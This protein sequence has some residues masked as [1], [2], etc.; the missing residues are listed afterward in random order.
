MKKILRGDEES[1]KSLEDKKNSMFERLVQ[2]LQNPNAVVKDKDFRTVVHTENLVHKQSV[3]K[4]KE[5]YAKRE[6]W[7]GKRGVCQTDEDNALAK[8]VWK[9]CEKNSEIDSNFFVKFLVEIGTP[10]DL[11]VIKKTLG[12]IF[13]VKSETY[14]ITE[15]NIV[16]LCKSDS[17]NNH[18]L[19]TVLEHTAVH[20]KSPTSDKPP[21]ISTISS[22]NI[23]K[24]LR[25]WWKVLDPRN[26]DQVPISEIS[27]FLM[28]KK[29]VADQ[30][31]GRKVLIRLFDET[32]FISYLQF[33]MVFSS[34]LI[35]LSLTQIFKKI[36]VQ[37][38]NSEHFSKDYCFTLLKK[39]MLMAGNSF[40][41]SEFSVDE[42][43]AAVKG[44]GK[45][46]EKDL[47]KMDYE[48]F[49]NHWGEVTGQRVKIVKK[50]KKK[51]EFISEKPKSSLAIFNR[52]KNLED[53][54][55]VPDA[56]EEQ[57]DFMIKERYTILGK[58]D[59]ESSTE[60]RWSHSKSLAY[61]PLSFDKS[62]IQLRSNHMEFQKSIQ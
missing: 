60:G 38:S 30:T 36:R 45:Y 39:K 2:K 33:T 46:Y 21:D 8:E 31:N 26:R 61:P 16:T 5:I 1:L 17:F 57:S 12:I 56:K 43:I 32:S 44:I 54:S 29:F 40:P 18:L 58:Y 35:K 47:G 34:A 62:S 27:E 11:N 25:I 48:N 28:E 55:V 37:I 4:A 59:I 3:V 7:M 50:N 19:E 9:L 53:I 52:N 10:I 23:E 51:E 6:I 49:R 22:V 41:V 14:K 24:L 15:T 42:G 13:H 20:L